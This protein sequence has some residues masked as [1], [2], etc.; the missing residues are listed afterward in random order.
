MLFIKK[1][2]TE[3]SLPL[4]IFLIRY[5]STISKDKKYSD[6]NSWIYKYV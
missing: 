2:K 6:I 1:N 3:N 4:E 5:I